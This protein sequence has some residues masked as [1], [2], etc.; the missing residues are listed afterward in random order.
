MSLCFYHTL[1][2]MVTSGSPF[3]SS[4]RRILLACVAGFEVEGKGLYERAKRVSVS[5]F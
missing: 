3:F 2:Y 5:S 1:L 4:T